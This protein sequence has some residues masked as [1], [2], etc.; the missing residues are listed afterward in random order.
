MVARTRPDWGAAADNQT[1]ELERAWTGAIRVDG[2]FCFNRLGDVAR[3][4]VV[5]DD[6]RGL[7]DG[8]SGFVGYGFRYRRDRAAIAV[9][10][11]FRSGSAF[12]PA[13][14]WQAD[15]CV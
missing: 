3:T 14:P 7:G 5:L 12:A 4:A 11:A 6:V 9:Q 2:N 13:R 8:R 15:A 1:P 10:T